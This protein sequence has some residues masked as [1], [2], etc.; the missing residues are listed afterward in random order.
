ML[1]LVAAVTSREGVLG[2][3]TIEGKGMTHSERTQTSIINHTHGVHEQLC[4][5]HSKS[6]HIVIAY[7]SDKNGNSN[8]KQ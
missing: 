6:K 1:S 2:A 3:V 5:V 8:C 7:H 4:Y